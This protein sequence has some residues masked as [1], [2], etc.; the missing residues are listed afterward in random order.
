M[1]VAPQ[2]WPSW[3]HPSNVAAVGTAAKRVAMVWSEGV[4]IIP[5]PF[6]RGGRRVHM[7]LRVIVT[8]INS[9]REGAQREGLL[10]TDSSCARPL[11]GINLAG[12]D[13]CSPARLYSCPQRCQT[14]RWYAVP[15]SEVME[16]GLSVP[17]KITSAFKRFAASGANSPRCPSMRQIPEQTEW[18]GPHRRV[19]R[20]WQPPALQPLAK[21]RAPLPCPTTA[22][23]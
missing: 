6:G 5:S 3:P 12:R 17:F 10:R 18:T 4:V 2:V 1:P 15:S 11:Y 23:H 14:V 7:R 19:F 8:V 20:R 13:E 22:S 16:S 9:A 21:K